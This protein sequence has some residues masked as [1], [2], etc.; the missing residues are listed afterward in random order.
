MPTHDYIIENQSAPN[1]RADLNQAL[2]AIVSNNS[3][4]SEPPVTYANMIWYDTTNDLLRMR[5]EADDAFITLGTLD[6]VAGTF[7]PAGLLNLTQAQVENSASTVFGQVSG[8]R[9]SQAVAKFSPAGYTDAQA[10][11]AQAGHAAGGVGSYAFLGVNNNGHTS[12]FGQ[13]RAGSQLFPAGISAFFGFAF[14][15]TRSVSGHAAQNSGRAGT[16]RCMGVV[17]SAPPPTGDGQSLFGASLWL[18]IS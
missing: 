13:T 11:A 16:W 9:L 17:R 6:Q 15:G 2:Q 18:R 3:S 4:T 1:F 10:R 5:N 12:T 7:A 8:Q 14:N